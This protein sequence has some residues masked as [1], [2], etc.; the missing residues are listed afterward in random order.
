M[1]PQRF[2]ALWLPGDWPSSRADPSEGLLVPE[3]CSFVPLD[4]AQLPCEIRPLRRRMWQDTTTTI[5]T[6]ELSSSV[7]A[8]AGRLVSLGMGS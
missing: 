2:G 4:E 6:L 8:F 3:D 5:P 7:P 1:A